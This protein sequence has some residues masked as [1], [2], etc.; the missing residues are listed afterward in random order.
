MKLLGLIISMII[1]INCFAQNYTRDFGLTGGT[2]SGICYRV[3]TDDEEAYEGVV[4]FKDNGLQFSGFKE[5]YRPAFFDLSDNLFFGYGFGGH[6]GFV[7]IDRYQFL[8]NSY[9]I[10]H[11]TVA[12]ILG[13]DG[14][15]GLEYR[16]R[17]LPFIIGI[18]YKP[19]MQFSTIQFFNLNLFDSGLTFKYRF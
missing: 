12:P 11:K 18:N 3:F 8:F 15:F 17:E 14:F 19:Y 4:S 7:Y 13:I 2:R 1:G 6:A 5:Y 10:D 16:I 9:Y